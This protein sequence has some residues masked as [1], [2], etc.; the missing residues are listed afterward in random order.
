[1]CRNSA[2]SFSSWS[3]S[4]MKISNYL[5]LFSRLL[6]SDVEFWRSC[7]ISLF[8]WSNME[9]RLVVISYCNWIEATWPA[10]PSS[11]FLFLLT[12]FWR[13][14]P[15]FVL[16]SSQLLFS[17]FNPNR[18]SLSISLR[19]FCLIWSNLSFRSLLSII[20]NYNPFYNLS[21]LSCSFLIV[22]VASSNYLFLS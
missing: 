10:F 5:S 19:L 7:S 21:S 22:N 2:L 1:M 6:I 20:L 8:F 16:P 14:V 4:A 15:C 11:S 18:T 3:F 9:S 12:T 17:T 13:W